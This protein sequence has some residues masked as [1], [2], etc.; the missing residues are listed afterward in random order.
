MHPRKRLELELRLHAQLLDTMQIVL[1]GRNDFTLDEWTNLCNSLTSFPF[2]PP[3]G[4]WYHASKK[5]ALLSIRQEYMRNS[6]SN[7]IEVPRN[8]AASLVNELA[9]NEHSENFCEELR[10][11]LNR[12][13]ER[14]KRAL[15]EFELPN[16]RT[17][18]VSDVHLGTANGLTDDLQTVFDACERG[19]RLVLLGDILDIWIDTNA[20]GHVNAI[21]SQEW[22]RL[23][24]RLER[25]PD[26]GVKVVYVPGN[27]DS[28]VFPL[29]AY[30][31][32]NWCAQVLARAPRLSNLLKRVADNPLTDVCEIHNPFYKLQVGGHTILLTH[33][34]MHELRWNFFGGNG[35]NADDRTSMLWLATLVFAMTNEYSSKLRRVY[36][37][38]GGA[39]KSFRK[40]TDIVVEVTNRE[41]E[42]FVGNE[43]YPYTAN[44]RG[45]FIAQ[46]AKRFADVTVE[47][48]AAIANQYAAVWQTHVDEVTPLAFVRQQTAAYIEANPSLSNLRLWQDDR[49][50]RMSL[51]PLREFAEFDR[52]ICGHFHAPRD[53]QNMFDCGGMFSGN[54]LTIRSC[55][56]IT[57]DGAIYRPQGFW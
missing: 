6:P 1:P 36:N 10:E 31:H 53:E 15:A 55:L 4:N 30:G 32:L 56:M 44:T 52:F 35:F 3:I 49:Q 2:D 22:R 42:Q 47:D 51:E 21:V 11:K 25:L 28:F 19:D 5:Q 9:A 20:E 45:A 13:A 7:Y 29:T 41:L 23:Y 34:H 57:S 37:V 14:T 54:A 43:G 50:P 12:R 26:R 16:N 48:L 8:V 39:W 38:V 18:V 33:G 27:H 17:F 40:H 46:V 24:V